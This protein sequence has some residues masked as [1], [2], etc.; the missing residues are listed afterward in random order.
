M[1]QTELNLY[2]KHLEILQERTTKVL[3][4]EGYDV[5]VIASGVTEYYFADDRP[6]AFKSVPHFTHWCPLTGTGHL[7]IISKDQK[8]KL[9]VNAPAD[10]WHLPTSLDGLDWLDNFNV[11]KVEDSSKRYGEIDTEG[12]KIAFVGFDKDV[13]SDYEKNPDALTKALDWNRS[14][15]TEWEVHCVDTANKIAAKGHM[16]AQ[17]SFE[18][19]GSEFEIYN[20]YLKATNHLASE[21]PYNAIIGLDEHA[22]TLHYEQ[23][24][25][26]GKGTTLLIDAGAVYHGYVSDITRTSLATN[27]RAS[28]YG[29]TITDRAH[30]TFKS[31]IQ[32]LNKSQ[33]SLVES[34]KAGDSYVELHKKCCLDVFEILSTHGIIKKLPEG[35]KW[36]LLAVRPFFPHGLGHM[37]GVQVHDVAGKQVNMSGDMFNPNTEFP[38]LRNYRKIE[39]GHMFTIEPGIYF[40]PTLIEK[41]RKE[42]PQVELDDELIEELVGLGGIRIEDNVYVGEDKTHN[43]TRKYLP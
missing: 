1:N 12:K 35:E 23:K 9:V 8:P 15:K 11:E 18:N 33:I 2:K 41:L 19:G 5:L 22:A 34:I 40:I 16:S 10:F 21:L 13:P 27:R 30:D 26:N 24:L 29:R 25:K 14:Y 31:L 39:V 43:L 37:L 3:D 38:T 36:K 17:E 28:I 7:L 20:D 4:S 32:T 42:Y 6:Y